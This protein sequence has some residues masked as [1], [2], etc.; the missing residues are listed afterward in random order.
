MFA[1]YLILI[2]TISAANGGCVSTLSSS[3]YTLA[4]KMD[5][6]NLTGTTSDIV[7]RLV[8]NW[9]AYTQFPGL[10]PTLDNVTESTILGN[11]SSGQANPNANLE[12]EEL[13]LR[14]GY[15]LMNYSVITED[16]YKLKI[17]RIKRNGPPVFLMH[18]LLSSSDDWMTAGPETSLAYLLADCGYDIWM[19]NARGNR[20]SRQN[21]LLTP[22]DSK[23]WDFSWHEIGVFDL[24]AMIDFVLK[25]TGQ[26]KLKYIGHSQ[27]TTSFYV[28]ASVK[29]EYN[30][31]IAI[32]ISLAPR[33]EENNTTWLKSTITLP[34]AGVSP[35]RPQKSFEDSSERSKRRRTEDLR[36]KDVVEL[37]Y[38]THMKLRHVGKVAASKV[39]KDLSKSPQ[40]AKKYVKAFKKSTERQDQPRQLSPL[41]A[42][43]M[44]TEAE[45]TKAQYERVRETNPNFFPCYSV[46]QKVKKDL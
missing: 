45:L 7:S 39:V 25:E 31:K 44:F 18:G 4:Q 2:A 9:S 8:A 26:T 40:R 24:P 14:Y 36:S 19:G 32:M 23:F 33:F 11:Y 15:P 12:I 28:M 21:V 43:S 42:L 27:G 3:L 13:S 1:I 29:P 30:K 5:K 22:S 10:L 46:L 20:H 34:S 41:Q 6:Y 16:G 35:G 17:Y 37:T 38:A